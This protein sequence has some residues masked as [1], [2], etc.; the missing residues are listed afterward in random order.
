M[1]QTIDFLSPVTNRFI[2]ALVAAAV[3][4]YLAV[5][6]SSGKANSL[7]KQWPIYLL[8]T[9]LLASL[10][11]LF[12]NPVRVTEQKGSIEPSQ[13]FFMLDASES[14]AI[15][16]QNATRWD[17]AVQLISNATQSAFETAAAEVSLF[18]FGRRL[19]AIESAAELGLE[20]ALT[21]DGRGITYVEKTTADS[22]GTGDY[23]EGEKNSLA[24]EPDTQ[25]FVALRQIS[26]RFGRKPPSAVVVFSDGRAR[27]SSRTAQVA[28]AFSKLNVPVH[29]VPVGNTKSGGDVALISLVVPY[30]ARKQSEVQAN[31]FLRSH[32]YDGERVEVRLHALDEEGRKVRR[33]ATV[34]VTLESGFQSVPVVF[35]TDADTASIQAEVTEQPNEVSTDNNKF[36]TEIMITREK[37][38]VLYIEGSRMRAIPVSRNGRITFQGPMSTLQ[39]ALQQ[40]VDIECVAIPV[41]ASQRRQIDQ[42]PKSVAELSAYDAIVL[43]DV[44]RRV[45]SQ[46]QLDWIEGWV[47]RRGGGLCM[48]GGRNSFSSGQWKGSPVERILPVQLSG[49]MDWRGDLKVAIQPDLEDNLHALFRFAGDEELNRKLVSAFPGFHGSNIGL[50]PKPNFAKVLAASHPGAIVPEE[51][52]GRRS[53]LFTANGIRDLLM[54]RAKGSQQETSTDG[55]PQEYAGITVGQY[56]KGRTM[57]LAMPITGAPA[58][59]F[60]KWGRTEGGDEHYASFWRN[61]IYWLTEKSY[62]GRRRLVAEADKRY[63]GPGDTITLT[64]SAFDESANETSDYR[65]VGVIEPQPEMYEHLESDYSMIRWPNNVPREEETDSPFAMWTERFEIPVKKIA[66]RNVY[67]IE[68][69]LAETLPSGMA[70]QSLRIELTAMEDQTQ[71]DSTSVPVSVL[72]DPFE[73]QNPSPDHELLET[74]AEKSGG[75]VLRNDDDLAAM[76]KDLPVVRGPS[77]MRRTPIWSNGWILIGILGLISTE[78]CYRRWVGLA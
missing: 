39:N 28:E 25:L 23:Y 72:H 78:W 16:N 41:S 1:N 15:G 64:G 3:V 51:K 77:E 63:Y 43:S 26:S 7:S 68:L 48:V 6:F 33:L 17:Q 24:N 75:Q 73:Q 62:V 9:L 70:N 67:Q 2:L 38:R 30:E 76:M 49:E 54:G 5:R 71:V 13:I 57:A 61:T 55:L 8:R 52:Q 59:D 21:D 69:T 74:L 47:K 19:K 50:L 42:F 40:D 4:A 20:D 18:R 56:G 31:A 60:L 34:P 45:F 58:N 37:I 65:L 29:T 14:M 66:G 46:K 35:R 12:A 27:D 10:L 36:D 32:G 53:P 22:E 11:A 44:P